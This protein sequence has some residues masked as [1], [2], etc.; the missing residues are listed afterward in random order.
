MTWTEPATWYANLPAFYAAAAACAREVHEEL[1]ISVSVGDLLVVDWAPPA[2][3]RPRAIISFTF[4]CGTISG[5]DG[6]D[7][8]QQELE[9]VA[10]FSSQEAEQQ[11][12]SNVAPRVRAT[13][14]ARARNVPPGWPR[15]RE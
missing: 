1:G 8:P 14:R 2:E 6:F 11:L 3:R 12:P 7:L 9:D 4:D 5:L 10:C 15:V 13:V